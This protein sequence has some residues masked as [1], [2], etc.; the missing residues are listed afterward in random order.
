MTRT[1]IVYL[2]A[3][4]ILAALFLGAAQTPP[5]PAAPPV[6]EVMAVDPVPTPAPLPSPSNY[7]WDNFGEEGG[8]YL[9]IDTQDVTSQRVAALKLKEERGVEVLTV[10]QDA[11]AGKAGVKEHDVIL[12]FNGE[13]V[14]GVEQLRRM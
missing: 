10:D 11:P 7:M 2:G 1:N 3:I 8:S 4:I 9:G 12:E 14:Q 13:K 6:P 5:T